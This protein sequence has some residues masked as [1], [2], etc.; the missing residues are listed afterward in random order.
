MARHT[1]GHRV[2]ALFDILARC[3]TAGVVGNLNRKEAAA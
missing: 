1:C 3:G 2:D